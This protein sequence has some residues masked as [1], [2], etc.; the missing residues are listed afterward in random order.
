MDRSTRNVRRVAGCVVAACLA[1]VL[2]QVVTE[3]PS[4]AGRQ[5]TARDLLGKLVVRVEDGQAGF[6][7]QE[8]GK[9]IDDDGDC[10]RTPA[11]VLVRDA[12]RPA[13]VQRCTVVNGRW[14]SLLDGQ[15]ISSPDR[16]V[17][18][19]VVPVREAWGSGAKRWTGAQRRA[20]INDLDFEPSLQVFSRVVDRER[21]SDD[22]ADWGPFGA[23][24]R[25]EYAANWV[26]VKWRWNL[27]IDRA[28]KAALSRMLR[29]ECGGVAMNTPPRV[30]GI[31]SPTPPTTTTTTT[32]AVTAP[33][34]TTRPGNPGDSKNCSDFATWSAA[35][36]WFDLYYPY[37]GDVA[38]LDSDDDRIACETLPG[39][40]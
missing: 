39:A 26:A 25:C 34:T 8:F 20:F 24:T 16:V 33:P 3:A 30:R 1:A 19:P 29:A 12:T 18:A 15:T 4:Q 7:V 6:D 11:E 2:V 17:V 31:P 22:P 37:Y 35:Q 23:A 38:N 27:S 14:L 28:E 10:L 13:A 32:T 36:A 5:T 9:F 40:P 21:G